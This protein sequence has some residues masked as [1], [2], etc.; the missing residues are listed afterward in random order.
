MKISTKGQYGVRAMFD[1]A[2]CYGQGPVSI[3]KIAGNQEISVAYLEQL[4]STLRKA[5]LIHSI[6]GA[7]GGFELAKPP[8]EISIGAVLLPLEGEIAP[9][10]CVRDE[11]VCSS[12]CACPSRLIWKN[13][14][15]K[16]NCL[17]DSISLQDMIDEY[18]KVQD[19]N[20]KDE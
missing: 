16:V 17:L 15:D 20:R 14:N 12:S 6:R 13:L 1:L 11:V 7:Q 2:M 10:K 3:S 5:G 4:F 18:K 9:V 19:V 8:G